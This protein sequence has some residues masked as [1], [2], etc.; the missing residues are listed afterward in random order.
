MLILT[1]MET[2]NNILNESSYYI[3]I[4]YDVLNDEICL[5]TRY[6]F[7]TKELADKFVEHINKTHMSFIICDQIEYEQSRNTSGYDINNPYRPRF[8]DL[9]TAI[10]DFEEFF[11]CGYDKTVFSEPLVNYLVR[12]YYKTIR[13]LTAENLKLKQELAKYQI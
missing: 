1:N 6:R 12:K 13:E 4:Y 2:P 11:K 5:E 10:K 3:D 7:L 8:S 9:E